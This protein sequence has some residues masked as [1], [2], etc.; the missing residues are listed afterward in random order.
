M[1]DIPTQPAPQLSSGLPGVRRWPRTGL[2]LLDKSFY[3]VAAAAVIWFVYYLVTFTTQ[4]GQNRLLLD[5]PPFLQFTGVTLLVSL[6]SIVVATL[7]GFIGALG[8]LSRFRV[9]RWLAATYV[10]VVRGTPL[11]VQ[12]LIWYYPIAQLLANVGFD[13]FT[14]AFKFM[15][16]LQSN[17]L[18]PDALNGYFYGIL[19]LSFNYGAY[20]TEVFR[21][22]IQGVDKGQT[23]AALSLG[24]NGRQVMRHIILPQAIRITVPP[25]T[26]YFITLIQDSSFL[27]LLGVFE[28]EHFTSL[29]AQPLNEFS[30]KMF[31]F[32]LGAAFYFAICFPLGRLARFLESRMAIAY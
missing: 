29:L 7:F 27:S 23:E 1:A 17:S 5:G 10:E 2:M 22:G 20:L 18:V 28:L 15:T 8:R 11:Y 30:Q 16:L 9:L 26:N 31:V 24:L 21:A 32:V 25:F 19:G 4:N 12:L 14:V 3:V 13:P 6:F